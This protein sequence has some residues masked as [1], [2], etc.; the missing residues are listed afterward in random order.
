LQQLLKGGLPG[1]SSVGDDLTIGREGAHIAF[2][3][4]P[5]LSTRHARVRRAENGSFLLEDTGSRNG[6]YLRIQDPTALSHGDY[7]FIGATLLRVDLT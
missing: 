4:D 5:F 3:A 7:L 2:T 1:L 6:T